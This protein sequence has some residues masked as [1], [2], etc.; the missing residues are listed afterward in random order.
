MRKL[1]LLF[2]LTHELGLLAQKHFLDENKIPTNDTSSAKFYGIKEFDINENGYKELTFFISGAKESET[3]YTKSQ[4]Q[5]GFIQNGKSMSWYENGQLK[6]ETN[7]INGKLN[8][9]DISYYENGQL[10]SNLTYKEGKKESELVSYW[11]NGKLKRKDR[12][13][14][15]N[16]ESGN[17]YDSL[18]N[19]I[20]HFD[21]EIMPQYKGGDSKLLS[22]IANNIEYPTNSKNAGIQGRVIV[23]FAI[24]SDGTISSVDILK[25]V[26]AELNQEAMRV[27]RKLKKFKPGYEDGEPV[28]VFYMVPINF[29]LK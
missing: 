16:F 5:A 17:C 4:N 12:Y 10:K 15:G 14:N 9:K 8:G 7:F 27:V 26:N 1:L 18:G 23:R 13:N 6:N 19:D 24:N 20:K 25:G 29:G 11:K 3:Y 21:Y 2:L 28:P 22:D